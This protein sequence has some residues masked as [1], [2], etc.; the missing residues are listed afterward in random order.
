[1]LFH[2]FSLVFFIKISNNISTL[3]FVSL[4]FLQVKRCAEMARKLRFF[5]DQINKSGLC[6]TGPP[7]ELATDFDELEVCALFQNC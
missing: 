3:K 6:P 2:R 1:M 5:R 7:R 4:V